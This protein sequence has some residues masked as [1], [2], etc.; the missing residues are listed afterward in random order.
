MGFYQF[1]LLLQGC[2]HSAGWEENTTRVVLGFGEYS[3]GN[4]VSGYLG[5]WQYC[6]RWLQVPGL[7]DFFGF[8][9]KDNK[10][11]IIQKNQQSDSY[12]GMGSE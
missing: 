12:C 3:L 6:S 8:D 1:V 2:V 9:H 4:P 10:I 5:D 7:I 11:P